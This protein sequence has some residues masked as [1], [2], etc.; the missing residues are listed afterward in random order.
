[1]LCFTLGILWVLIYNVAIS[2]ALYCGQVVILTVMHRAVVIPRMVLFYEC[3]CLCAACSSRCH[4][5]RRR[6]VLQL[7]WLRAMWLQ[8]AGKWFIWFFKLFLNLLSTLTT[9]LATDHVTG[10][11]TLITWQFTYQALTYRVCNNICILAIDINNHTWTV[12]HNI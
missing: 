5:Q 7:P 12:L 11:Q 6:I 1:M 4:G 3:V 2:S 10:L 9:W 8:M